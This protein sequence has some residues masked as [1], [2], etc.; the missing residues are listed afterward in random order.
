MSIRFNPI[1]FQKQ[2]NNQM[3]DNRY[4]NVDG[5]VMTGSLSVP[6]LLVNS[7]N[8]LEQLQTHQTQI[9]SK[10]NL[11]TSTNKISSSNV[12]YT[13][14][15]LQYVDINSNLQQ[16]LNSLTQ[17]INT[18]NTLLTQVSS[19]PIG[20][21]ISSVNSIVPSGYLPMVGTLY[22]ISSYTNLYNVIIG[23]GWNN[24]FLEGVPTGQFFI[25][26]LR[27]MFLRGSGANS[28]STFSNAVGN[29]LGGFQIDS[30]K[31]HAHQYIVSTGTQATSSGPELARN[32]SSSTW[33]T[34]TNV[35]NENGV[36]IGQQETKPFNLSVNWFI[37][38]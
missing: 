32:N 6:S 25:P 31:V 34:T 38:F 17:Q 9:N 2:T 26:D 19:I 18:L 12:D 36:S 27:G 21:I 30:I 16:Q 33:S 24:L 29:S 23:L 8:V 20:T 11:I 10:Q 37:K 14:S 28:Y 22:P 7:V 5:D 1:D 3:N 35:F 13:G 4:V 15:S